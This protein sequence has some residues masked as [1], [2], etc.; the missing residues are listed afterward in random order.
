PDATVGTITGAGV[1]RIV[2]GGDKGV[3]EINQDLDWVPGKAETG[4]GFGESIDTDDYN[5]DGYTDLVVGIPS[6]DLGTMTDAGM[7]EVLYGAA[8]GLGTGE[9]TTH[10]EQG[11]GEG[12]IARSA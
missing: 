7:V 9:Q 8:D 5:E 3:A 6:E 12:A 1:V 2:Y 4:D 11:T 10:L